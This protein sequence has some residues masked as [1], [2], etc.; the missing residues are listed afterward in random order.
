MI[1]PIDSCTT[2]LLGILSPSLKLFEL[3]PPAPS[4][5]QA[6]STRNKNP[7]QEEFDIRFAESKGDTIR[8]LKHLSMSVVSQQSCEIKINR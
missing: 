2:G 4:K 3:V 6:V 1:H 5:S 8:K 7:F